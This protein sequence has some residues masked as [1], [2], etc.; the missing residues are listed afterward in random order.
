MSGIC[1][2]IGFAGAPELLETMAAPLSRFDPNQNQSGGDKPPTNEPNSP[3]RNARD[4]LANLG[5]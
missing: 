2:W 3:Q 4:R 5:S 1:G